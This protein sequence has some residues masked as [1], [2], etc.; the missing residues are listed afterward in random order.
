MLRRILRFLLP[1]AIT[2][3][4]TPAATSNTAPDAAGAP[5]VIAH[6]GASAYLPEHTLAAKAMAHAMGADFLEQ[7]V[8]LT[9]DGQAIVLHDLYLE[10]LTDVARRFP[11]RARADGRWYA[12]DF[13]LSEIRTLRLHERRNPATGQPIFPERFPAEA[14]L[15]RIHTLEDELSLI[16]GL[17]RSTGRT[18]GIY[19][20][21]KHPAWHIAEGLD[22]VPIVMRELDRAG[23]RGLEDH[24]Y[25]QCFE[26]DTLKRLHEEIGTRIPLIQLIGENAWSPDL[27]VDFERMRTREGLAAVA[28]YAHGIGPWIGQ[29]HEGLD[30][31]GAHRTTRLVADAHAAGLLVH[32]YT[33]RR[34]ALPEGFEDFDALLRFFLVDQRVEGIFTDHP[35]LAVRFRRGLIGD[36][37]PK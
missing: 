33:F 17:N 7:D 13:S 19:V 8:V 9:R 27:S 4:P 2:M 30:D 3:T 26:P 34:D 20:E 11:D 12:I 32:P 29:I 5:I 37:Q 10:G 16:R 15:F 21:L 18:A 28:E 1:M 36:D 6:R 24:V 35:D 23:Y 25:I 14:D 31:T 22:P